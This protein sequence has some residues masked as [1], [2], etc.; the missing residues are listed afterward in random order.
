MSP[1]IVK[2][3]HKECVFI[4]DNELLTKEVPMKEGELER[5]YSF[6]KY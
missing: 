5:E 4:L 1:F 3:I 6:F 2:R